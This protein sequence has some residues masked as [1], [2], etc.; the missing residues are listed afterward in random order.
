MSEPISSKTIIE[1]CCSLWWLLR[2][3][4]FVLDLVVPLWILHNTWYVHVN[5]SFPLVI[6]HTSLLQLQS[7]LLKKQQQ[8]T[9]TPHN[10]S[11]FRK[12]ILVCFSLLYP[13]SG[14]VTPSALVDCNLAESRPHG[15][16]SRE[17]ILCVAAHSFQTASKPLR[18]AELSDRVCEVC[19]RVG[20]APGCVCVSVFQ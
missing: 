17:E 7:I 12:V 5:P 10:V 16:L 3:V 4:V 20:L 15:F 13:S 2:T 8:H 11:V 18:N 14:R 6:I 9:V 19:C 1:S